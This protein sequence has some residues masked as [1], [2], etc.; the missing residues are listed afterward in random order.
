VRVWDV[1]PGYLSRQ[2]LLGEHRELHGLHNIVALG[3]T[4][5]S[6]H[7]ET[8]RWVRALSGLAWRHR[9]LSA[10]MRL[11]GYTDRTPLPVSRGRA[12]WP[13]V[14]I[15]VPA[16]QFQLLRG[17]YVGRPAGRI[18]L[19]RSPQ[20]LWS[21]HKYSVL[22]RDQEAYRRIGRWVSRLRRGAPLADLAVDLVIAVRRP[23]PRG[24]L[25]NAVEHMWGH[26]NRAA[27]AAETSAARR[28]LTALL[29]VTQAVAVREREPFL[30]ASTALGEL[31]AYL[32]SLSP[33]G[34]TDGGHGT[35]VFTAPIRSR[36]INFTEGE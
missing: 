35:T 2:S 7:P 27:T 8:L 3:R 25:A 1:S 29:A 9:H 19:P 23:P 12:V 32:P 6:R 33:A 30:L 17:K 15:D 28:S 4:G 5:Y 26:V 18:S 31:S 24:A 13:D 34:V 16:D 20:E 36:R 22:A 11:R 10:E 21:H 14:F